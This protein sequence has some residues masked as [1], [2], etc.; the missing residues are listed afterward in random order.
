MR[1]EEVELMIKYKLKTHFK[2]RFRESIC[3][4]EPSSWRQLN[5]SENEKEVSCKK[6]L[7]ILKKKNKKKDNADK[8]EKT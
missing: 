4:Q 5:I 3:G 1:T 6:C 8:K 7:N 2:L